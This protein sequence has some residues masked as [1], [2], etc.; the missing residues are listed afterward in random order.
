MTIKRRQFRAIG[1][2]IEKLTKPVFGKRGFGQAAIVTQ[3][4]E[5][6]GGIL[7]EHTFPE[8]IAYPTGR[9]A[10]GTL[11]LRIDSSALA[12]ELQHLEP[13]ITEKINTFFGFKA[14]V[15]IKIIQGPLPERTSDAAP[16]PRPL[17][18]EEQ[19]SLDNK[20]AVVTDPQLKA[21][22]TALGTEIVRDS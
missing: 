5:I 12:L 18:P 22:L 6:I 1:A 2:T 7:A 21:A 19:Q 3:W 8:R 9:R 17:A 11:H 13:Q 14:V 15:R 16:P 10:E 20:L 4:P